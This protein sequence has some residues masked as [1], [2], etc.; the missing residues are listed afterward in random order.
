MRL[1]LQDRL[2]INREVIRRKGPA[3]WLWNSILLDARLIVYDVLGPA[4]ELVAIC[5]LA[6]AALARAVKP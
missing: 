5:R 4:R 3:W 6:L 1:T 2:W